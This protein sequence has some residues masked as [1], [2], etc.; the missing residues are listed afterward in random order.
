MHECNNFEQ[1]SGRDID[2]FYVYNKKILN[3]NDDK[4]FFMKIKID[5]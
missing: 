1:L 5:F 4:D 3:I 2:S